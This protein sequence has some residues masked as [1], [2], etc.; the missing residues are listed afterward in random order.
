MLLLFPKPRRFLRYRKPW[1]HGSLLGR[2][3]WP[4]PGNPTAPPLINCRPARSFHS[5]QSFK[6]SVH[7]SI[8]S[9]IAK[10][11]PIA[12]FFEGK[13]RAFPRKRWL[14]PL[15]SEAPCGKFEFCG[16]L[17]CRGSCFGGGSGSSDPRVP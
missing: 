1:G 11:K 12:S 13:R 8:N 2:L 9:N 4:K 7:L 17:G 3:H 14:K 15:Q 5:H 16:A 10:N 6:P